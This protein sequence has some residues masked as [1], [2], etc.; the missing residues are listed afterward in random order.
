MRMRMRIWVAALGIVAL[1]GTALAQGDVIAQR[2]EGLKRMGGHMDAMKGLVASR[3]DT[4]P[5]AARV[6]DMIAWYRGFPALFPAGS[7][8]GDTKALPAVWTDRAGFETANANLLRQLDVLKS[9]AASGDQAAFA[10]A[11]QATGP[12][13]CGGCHR[14]FRAR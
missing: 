14:P 12:Q 13:F 5:A 1:A 4:R 11:Y 7:D 10:A 9:A 3:G 2:R 8:R 6:D